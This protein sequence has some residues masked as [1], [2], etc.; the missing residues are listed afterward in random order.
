VAALPVQQRQSWQA[1]AAQ[2][3]FHIRAWNTKERVPARL[4]HT[5]AS[6]GLEVG[7]LQEPA[8]TGIS[9]K[10]PKHPPTK[11]SLKPIENLLSVIEPFRCPVKRERKKRTRNCARLTSSIGFFCRILP[12]TVELFHQL[13][14]FILSCKPISYCRFKRIDVYIL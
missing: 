13:A 9:T 10:W 3:A 8:A 12:L 1:Y 6:Q 2:E 4:R 11:T 5:I 7:P 14:F